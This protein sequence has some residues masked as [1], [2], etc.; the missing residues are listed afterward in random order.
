ME[1]ENRRSRPVI[2]KHDN[3]LN[4]IRERMSVISVPEAVVQWES[5]WCVR[6]HTILSRPEYR[7]GDDGV[8]ILVFG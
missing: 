3:K 5:R 2:E 6:Q 4:T 1:T 7:I 8:I